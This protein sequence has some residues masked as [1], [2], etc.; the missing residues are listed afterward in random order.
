MRKLDIDRLP[1][2]GE[3]IAG[4]VVGLLLFIAAVAATYGLYRLML[5]RGASLAPIVM[6]SLAACA[7]LYAASL[8]WRTVRG[9]VRKSGGTG[10]WLLGSLMSA[11]ALSSAIGW[12]SGGD[13]KL[14]GYAVAAA[15]F[16]AVC[17]RKAWQGR[18]STS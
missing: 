17:F 2:T 9:Q 4:F 11:L 15:T 7:G 14:V 5:A 13:I 3:R 18:S 16:G 6:L 10:L 1:T 8:L 12:W